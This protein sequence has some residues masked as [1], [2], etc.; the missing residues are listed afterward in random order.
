MNKES[1]PV[2]KLG[3]VCDEA[4]EI[5]NGARQHEYGT[6]IES[7]E[8]IADYWNTYLKH[9]EKGNNLKPLTAQDVS[10]L[11]VLFKIAR[12]ENKHK[13]DN[14][15]DIIGYTALLDYMYSLEELYT[16][17]TKKMVEGYNG[18]TEMS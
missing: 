18:S 11:M 15:T 14:L 12:Q 13:H 9:I 4:K 17:K 7:F 5:I 3:K 8:R 1:T 10:M 2:I 6:P 16:R